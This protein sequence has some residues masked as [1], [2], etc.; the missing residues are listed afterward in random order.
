MPRNEDASA[1][2]ASARKHIEGQVMRSA[3][4]QDTAGAI[5]RGHRTG[6]S[7]ILHV[8]TASRALRDI[9]NASTPPSIRLPPVFGITMGVGS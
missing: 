2:E 9:T 7:R 4:S 6:M 1:T 3:Q 8:A 5:H